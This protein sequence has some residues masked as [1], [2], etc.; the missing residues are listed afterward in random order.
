MH[1]KVP[2]LQKARSYLEI[3]NKNESN[4][5]NYSMTLPQER[6]RGILFK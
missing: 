3:Y 6:F 2:I 4:C 1:L 5:I